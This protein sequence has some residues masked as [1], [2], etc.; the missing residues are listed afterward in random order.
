MRWPFERFYE[1]LSWIGLLMHRAVC[2]LESIDRTLRQIRA[3]LLTPPPLKVRMYGDYP[4][5]FELQVP[6]R[7]VPDVVKGVLNVKVGEQE[8]IVHDFIP[9]AP[10]A[11]RH[12]KFI[13]NDNDIVY[14]TLRFVDDAGNISAPAILEFNLADTIPPPTPEGFSFSI[15]SEEEPSPVPNPS[16]EPEPVILPIQEPTPEPPAAA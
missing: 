10:Q 4:M 11:I 9:D 15:V 5:R 14:A 1:K 7:N 6:A 12:P 8:L 3:L 2:K 13:G 16:P